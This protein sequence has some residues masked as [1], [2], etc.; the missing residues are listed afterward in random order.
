MP[1][2]ST[3]FK[4]IPSRS[5]YLKYHKIIS[6]LTAHQSHNKTLSSCQIFHNYNKLYKI[7]KYCFFLKN[8]QVLK[9]TRPKLF[10]FFRSRKMCLEI[11]FDNECWKWDALLG[12]KL[13]FL[14]FLF[15]QNVVIMFLSGVNIL[16]YLWEMEKKYFFLIFIKIKKNS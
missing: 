9:C 11:N 4:Q 15:R 1:P 3:S 10:Y 13:H 12:T 5:R 6:C 16:K 2:S 7:T 8:L 14:N